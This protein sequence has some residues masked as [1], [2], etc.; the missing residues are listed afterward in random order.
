MDSVT[1]DLIII[2]HISKDII[3][4]DDRIDESIGGSVYYAAL[5]AKPAG[6]NV[7]AITKLALSEAELLY[8][9]WQNKVPVLPLYTV[10]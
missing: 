1:F 10:A 9:F 7:L 3:I 6:C 2:G 4:I 5:A 8:G